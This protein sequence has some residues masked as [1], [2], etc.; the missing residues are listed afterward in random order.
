MTYVLLPWRRYAVLWLLRCTLFWHKILKI[1][2]R[3]VYKLAINEQLDTKL[4]EKS[5]AW[6]SR[7]NTQH[8]RSL[9]LKCCGMEYK[10]VKNV[11][12]INGFIILEKRKQMKCKCAPTTIRY[13]SAKIY[14][15]LLLA[16]HCIFM[17]SSRVRFLIMNVLSLIVTRGFLKILGSRVPVCVLAN[18]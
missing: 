18:T 4:R 2:C 14:P 6:K 11:L 15:S 1:T 3:M 16:L 12:W 10:P 13:T 7:F 5:L 9:V 8:K 17:W